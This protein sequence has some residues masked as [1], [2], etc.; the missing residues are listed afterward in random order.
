[1]RDHYPRRSQIE[2]MISAAANSNEP[3]VIQL[4]LSI[5]RRHRTASVQTRARELVEQIAQ[6]NGWSADEL[7]DRTIPSAGFDES[8]VL[9]LHYGERLFTA[10]LDA[11]L[12][13]ELCNPD[14]KVVKA[15]PEPRKSDDPALIKEAKSQFSTSKK[16]L[17][18]VIDLQSQR[19]YEAMCAA[20]LWPVGEWREYL[21]QHP[22][23]GHL[24]QRLVWAEV[25][26]DGATRLFRPTEDG[27][28]IDLDDDEVELADD[29]RI[30]LAH[31]ALV[32]GETAK[33]WVRH[34]K[35][36]KVKPLFAQMSRQLP[37]I[38]PEAADPA[39]DNSI[40]D[41]LGWLSDTFTLR[42]VLTKLG[43]QRAAAE[44]GGFFDHYFKEFTSLGLRVSI[45]F[46]GNCLPEENVPAALT[47]LAF[48]KIG[49]RWSSGD[50]L[51]L[52]DIPPV[53]LAETYADYRA[54]ADAC[55]GFDPQWEKKTPW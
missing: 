13:L 1:M 21:Q 30:R 45:G 47:R 55:V 14:G 32:D 29:S 12:K 46:T 34:F 23:M 16:E 40:G 9:T 20:R 39:S 22:I 48:E 26:A 36:Y 35:D 10:R 17:K 3:L 19:L 53:L 52:A 49:R 5:A 42:G 54:A 2:A 15:L 44:D 33:G 28:L 51:P 31:A 7:A 25:G 6:R 43:Y 4:L 27:S 41:R 38:A 50:N 8:G 18:Q 37:E 24:L 11:A